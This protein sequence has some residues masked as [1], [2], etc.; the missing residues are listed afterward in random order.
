[1]SSNSRPPQA[2]LLP[3][4]FAAPRHLALLKRPDSGS[5]LSVGALTLHPDPT[6]HHLHHP[7]T[8]HT[9]PPSTLLPLP[10]LLPRTHSSFSHF[11]L[12]GLLSA[13]CSGTALHAPLSHFCEGAK[14]KSSFTRG[15]KVTNSQP[16]LLLVVNVGARK[17][18]NSGR[19]SLIWSH[20]LHF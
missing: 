17:N 5:G 18:K 10:A 13:L 1:M 20:Y 3:S 15:G 19:N 8:S 11:T 7:V 14:E 9:Y 4:P 6:R 16:D 2:N 12:R